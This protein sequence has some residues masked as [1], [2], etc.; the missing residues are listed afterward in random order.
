MTRVVNVKDELCDV[1]IDRSTKW[2]NPFSHREGT[3]AEYLVSTRTEAI[4]KYREYLE[5]N[6]ELLGCLLELDGKVL[7]CH[8]KPKA[9]HGDVLVEFIEKM[10][11]PRLF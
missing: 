6:E 4:Q 1:L 10:K 11:K 3:K 9:C 2:G 5:S 8:C 7:W